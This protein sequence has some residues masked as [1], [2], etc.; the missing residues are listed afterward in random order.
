ML[1]FLDHK[2]L[3]IVG[4]TTQVSVVTGRGP[5][6]LRARTVMPTHHVVRR[7][8]LAEPLREKQVGSGADHKDQR[9]EPQAAGTRL[10]FALP[11]LER[12]LPLL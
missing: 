10:Q 2:K 9:E 11:F 5:V 7:P 4:V 3:F 12:L 8:H 6:I 1:L